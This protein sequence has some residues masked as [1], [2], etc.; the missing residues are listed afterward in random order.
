MDPEESQ[1]LGL[2]VGMSRCAQIVVRLE[3]AKFTLTSETLDFQT[4]ISLIV[5]EKEG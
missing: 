4:A 5:C 2:R 1:R 3:I